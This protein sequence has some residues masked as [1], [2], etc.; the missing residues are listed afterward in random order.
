MTGLSHG[1]TSTFAVVGVLALFGA[2]AAPAFAQG[3]RGFAGPRGGGEVARSVMA[4]L[5]GLELSDAQRQQIRSITQNHRS[6]FQALAE[7]LRTAQ[8]RLRDATTAETV[9]EAA[10]RSAAAQLA[11]VQADGAVLRARVHQEVWSVLTPEQQ[12]KATAWRAEREQRREQRRD[13]MEERLKQRRAN[14]V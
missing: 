12:Q 8:D 4:G 9:N 7:R 2:G 1:K 6:D 14:P 10:I 3:A 11:D 5:R 13:R